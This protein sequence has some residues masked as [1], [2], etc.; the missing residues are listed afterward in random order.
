MNEVALF[1]YFNTPIK[2]AH[3]LQSWVMQVTVLL[4]QST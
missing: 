4:L 1:E 3:A 2:G